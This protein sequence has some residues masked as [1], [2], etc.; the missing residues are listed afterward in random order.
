M[1]Y[2]LSI[3][4]RLIPVIMSYLLLA[5]HFSRNDSF[6]LVILSFGLLLLLLVRRHWVVWV[7]Q[8]A[9]ILGALEWIRSMFG[10]IT[11]RQ[12]IGEDW[13]RLAIILTAVALFTGLSALAFRNRKLRAH[14]H[15]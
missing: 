1:R 9:L 6:L 12:S 13:V 11:Y 2:F 5:A 10:Y 4:G 3:L 7:S 8:A 15:R 14:Y